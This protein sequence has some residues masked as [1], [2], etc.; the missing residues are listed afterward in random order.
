MHHFRKS[1]KCE[2]PSKIKGF[3]AFWKCTVEIG[4][5]MVRHS[6]SLINK[7]LARIKKPNLH[8]IYTKKFNSEK[9]VA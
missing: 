2:K 9:S 4:G 6:E 1:R 3:R 8:Q 5:E 7:G